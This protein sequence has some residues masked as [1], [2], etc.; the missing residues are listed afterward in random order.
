[1]YSVMTLRRLL[2][3]CSSNSLYI[4]KYII[5]N[6]TSKN[7]A[8]NNSGTV[9][10]AVYV[11][12]DK[13]NDKNIL[14]FI[15]QD[16]YH[17]KKLAV[18]AYNLNILDTQ[19]LAKLA[20]NQ[21]RSST[22]VGGDYVVVYNFNVCNNLNVILFNIKPTVLKKGTSIFQIVYTDKMT[23]AVPKNEIN[24]KNNFVE[25][26]NNNI[27]DTAVVNG[28]DTDLALK[29]S[30]NSQLFLKTFGKRSQHEEND[31]EDDEDDDNDSEIEEKGSNNRVGT[32]KSSD[33]NN[34]NKFNSNGFGSDAMDYS[35]SDYDSSGELSNKRQ[36]LDN[37]LESH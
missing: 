8:T 14:S 16:E 18:G 36:K 20:Q 2:N 25:G 22:I 30:T 33:G 21:C 12:L 32:H 4:D 9:D 24:L 26:I 28:N 27:V 19:L 29:K 31:D 37:N 11:T 35:D 10:I 34:N 7:M 17:L 13:E 15:V 3:S 23:E 1:M 6:I 5:E